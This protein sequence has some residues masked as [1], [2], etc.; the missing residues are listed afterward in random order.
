MALTRDRSISRRPADM[1]TYLAGVD[2]LYKGGLATLASGYVVAGQDVAGHRFIGVVD[3]YVDA[4]AVAAGLK[5]VKVWRD[6][7][8]LL[9]FYGTA[10]VTDIGKR[11]Y[12]KNDGQVQ[13]AQ[14]GGGN[15]WCGEIVGVESTSEVWVDIGPAAREGQSNIQVLKGSL[16]ATTGTSGGGALSLANPFGERVVVM[17]VILDVTTKS[18]GAAAVDAGIAANGTTSSDT[19]LDGLDVGTSAIIGNNIDNKGTHGGRGI[20]WSSSQYITVTASATLAGLVGTYTIVCDVP[21]AK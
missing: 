11:V 1:A 14:P 15:V 13:L 17:D 9:P 12:I 16:T 6:G 18:S 5:S 8:F 7:Q 19:L 20:A 2:K 3:E 21:T 10:A 4:S